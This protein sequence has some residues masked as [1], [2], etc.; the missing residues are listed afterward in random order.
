MTTIEQLA[1][2]IE[3]AMPADV[4]EREVVAP[5]GARLVIKRTRRP[6][7]WCPA[8]GGDLAVNHHFA[9]SCPL[10]K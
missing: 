10:R 3:A 9:A 7:A 8:C 6:G 5:N 1:E 2:Q 4:Y